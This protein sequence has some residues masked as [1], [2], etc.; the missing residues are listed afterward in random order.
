M[1][2]VFRLTA[3]AVIAMGLA[4]ACGSKKTVEVEDTTADTLMTVEA[5]IDTVVEEEPVVVEEEPAKPATRKKEVKKEEPTPANVKPTNIG[6]GNNTN[7]VP[8]K[9]GAKK[10]NQTVTTTDL[11]NGASS[12]V[13]TKLKKNN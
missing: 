2:K 8:T 5:V 6:E 13:P 4:T 1:K 3:I 9:T 12:N 7:N 10:V 11:N